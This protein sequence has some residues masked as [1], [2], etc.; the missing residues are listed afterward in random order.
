M[1]EILASEND[2]KDFVQIVERIFNAGLKL[3]NP[4]EVFIIKVDHW[5]DFKWLAF[6]HKTLGAL[7]VWSK[8][9]RIPPFIPNRIIEEIYF[10]K[11]A[12]DYKWEV[13]DPLHIYQTSENNA[14]RKLKCQSAY[15][16]W[17][18]GDTKNNSQGSLMVY[19]F[20]KD[21]QKA[22]Y[23]SFVK[24]PAWQIYKTD[25]ISRAE[26]KSMIENDYLNLIR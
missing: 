3:G 21:F 12:N 17:F 18:S 9:L 4:E 13:S 24:N 5:F 20:E 8:P 23:V 11:I 26:V 14:E 15:F 22:W 1:I 25:K 16:I 7:G 6:S 10:Q 2:D 19:S